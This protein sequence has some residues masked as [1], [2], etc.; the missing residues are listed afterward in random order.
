MSKLGKRTNKSFFK[1][2][3]EAKEET[4]DYFTP[5][6]MDYWGLCYLT[7]IRK[8]DARKVL[9]AFAMMNYIFLM[10]LVIKHLLIHHREIVQDIESPERSIT[11]YIGYISLIE[12]GQRILES[13]MPKTS[14][15]SK[16]ELPVDEGK[17]FVRRVSGYTEDEC[18]ELRIRF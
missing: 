7:S 5:R 13:I 6:L 10:D 17:T 8:K 9:T 15:D 16:K 11:S 2:L 1:R 4:G 18:I 14:Y 12:F 3:K